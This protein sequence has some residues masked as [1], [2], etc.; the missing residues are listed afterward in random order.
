[1]GWGC[2]CWWERGGEW[3]W[4]WGRCSF[5][6]E[7]FHENSKRGHDL[8]KVCWSWFHDFSGLHRPWKLL[9]RCSC[10]CYVPV[11]IA[12]HR[13][14]VEHLCHFPTELVHQAWECQWTQSSGSM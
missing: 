8:W 9:D 2:W 6:N 13:S 5:P 14:D 12:L 1:M 10:W 7:N 11:Q 3:D 4:D